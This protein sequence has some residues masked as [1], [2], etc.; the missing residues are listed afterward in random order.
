MTWPC[1]LPGEMKNPRVART[2]LI[3]TCPRDTRLSG[4]H[5]TYIKR[6]LKRRVLKGKVMPLSATHRPCLCLVVPRKAINGPRAYFGGPRYFGTS[7]AY[8]ELITKFLDQ[9]L[10][11]L[12]DPGWLEGPTELDSARASHTRD[13]TEFFFIFSFGQS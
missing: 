13:N 1:G 5:E 12:T 8:L 11:F 10:M 9:K 7:H 6:H 2:A 4:P 3:D